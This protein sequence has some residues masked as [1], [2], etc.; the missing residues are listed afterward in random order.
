[1][2]PLAFDSLLNQTARAYAYGS[3]D[4]VPMFVLGVNASRVTSGVYDEEAEDFTKDAIALDEWVLERVRELLDAGR[5]HAAVDAALRTPQS[6][7]F[8]HLLGLDTTGHSYRPHSPEYRGNTIVVDAIAREVS[9]LFDAYFEDNRTAFLL[10]ADHG[11]SRRGNHG[12]GDPDNTRTPLVAWGAG[13]PAPESGKDTTWGL[14]TAPKDVEQADL[15]P[16]MAAWLGVPVPANSEGH[17]PLDLLDAPPGYR[18]RAALATARQVLEVYRVKHA[19]RSARML[20]FIDFDALPGGEQGVP[21]AA[22]IADIEM[23]IATGRFDD[24]IDEAEALVTDALDGARYLHQYDALLLSAI[25]VAGYV[26]LFCY[27]ATHL[28]RHAL[29]AP[30]RHAEKRWPMRAIGVL[31]A[32]LVALWARLWAERAPPMYFAYSCYT[33]I[34][35]MATLVRAHVLPDVL[36]QLRQARQPWFKRTVAYLVLS[37]AYLLIAAFGYE[38]RLWWIVVLMTL[39]MVAWTSVTASFRESHQIALLVWIVLCTCSSWFM[40]LSTEK[41]ESVPLLL[42]GGC[43]LLLLGA[44]VLGLPRVFLQPSDYLGRNRRIFGMMHARSQAE[45][46]VMLKEPDE[47]ELG[48]DLF[49]PRTRAALSVELVA[50]LVT[51]GVT[52]SSAASLAAKQGL[53]RLNQVLGWVVMGVSLTVPF[54]IGF[55]RPRDG[56]DGRVHSQPVRERLV[57]LIFAFAP[58][59]VLLSLRDEVLFYLCYVLLLLTWGHL[60]AERARERSVSLVQPVQQSTAQ[61]VPTP[62]AVAIPPR[63]MILD[64]VRLGVLFLLL[65]HIGFFGTGNIASISSFYLS[66]VYRLVPVFQ[67]FLMAALLVLKL[68]VPF[69]LVSCVLAAVCKQPVESRPLPALSSRVPIVTS[70]IGLREALIPLVVA[71]LA[72]D[73]LALYFFFSIRVEGSWLEIGQSITHFVMANLLQVFMLA[74][75]TLSAALMGVAGR[76]AIPKHENKSLAAE[77]AAHAVAAATT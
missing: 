74:I 44:L 3:P 33:C 1:M 48:V 69:V 64:D 13:I 73:L 58:L 63:G 49:W 5:R 50:L 77:R 17:L 14:F 59:M 36:A 53:P 60:E 24:A 65:F 72:C 55:Q 16:L 31:G 71:A 47:V 38:N 23:Q 4:I 2:N 40:S 43:G 76:S 41:D 9:A 68:M 46:D 22:R 45:L 56:P 51:M 35:W 57:L 20:W 12:D 67:P 15:A 21:G 61:L 30:E 11:M 29:D 32:V 66:P 52:S 27:G 42:A 10:T 25:V 8:L 54:A 34:I 37:F 26:G 75:T 7:F 70:G 6:V 62:L 28:L 19:D 18:A 39:P